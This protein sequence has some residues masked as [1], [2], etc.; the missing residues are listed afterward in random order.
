MGVPCIK[1]CMTLLVLSLLISFLSQSRTEAVPTY[2]Y[3]Y[4]G[5][6]LN[7]TVNTPYQSNLNQLLA[8]LSSNATRNIEFYN[9][10]ASAMGSAD[11]V[12]GLFICRGDMSADVC[13][14]CVAKAT[15]D[16]VIRCPVQKSAMIWYEECMVRYSFRYI[17]SSMATDPSAFPR[18]TLNMSEPDR[19]NQLVRATM[20]D[21]ASQLSNVRA[22]AKKFGTK[23]ATFTPFKFL[24]TLAQCTPDLTGADC[25]RCLVIAINT[26]PGCCGGKQMG[27]VLFL[28]CIVKYAVTPFYQSANTLAPTPPQDQVPGSTIS[29]KG[30]SQIS[31]QTIVVVVASIS[32]SA[33]LFVAGYCYLRRKQRKKYNVIQEENAESLQFDF[34][35]IEGATDKFSDD[36]K[37]GEGGFGV[38]YK[39]ILPNGQEIAVK[40]LS[41]TSGQG[42]GE[43]KN[44]VI[45]VAKLQHRNLVRLLGFFL[46]GEEKILVYEF[47]PNKSLDYFLYD[48]KRREQ[49]DW[50]RRYKI[51]KGIARGI[52]YLH[53]D[54][55]LRVIHRDLKASNILLDQ[56]MNPKISDFGMAKIFGINQTQGNTNRI[57]GTFGYMSPEYA[58]FGQFSLKSDVYSFG[59]LILEILTGEKN[60]SFC[61]ANSSEVL[62]SYA[63]K[64]WRDETPLE[65]LDPTLGDSYTKNEVIRSLHIGLHCVQD[66]PADRPTMAT[67]VLMLNNDSVTLPLPQRPAYFFRS[68][69]DDNRRPNELESNQSTSKSISYSANEVSITE[70]YP[71]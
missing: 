49:L 5:I 14:D 34:A 47:V 7:F 65:L 55:R 32:V 23:E 45:T 52:L 62:L 68:R 28:S 69:T 25:N 71:R 56:D 41:Q 42:L 4:C 12:Y 27:S 66:N 15:K 51:I 50:S 54:S 48:P 20:N 22:G 13:R 36:N 59:V 6:A 2:T 57:V 44:E 18:S 37:L 63:W 9:A 17:F 39:G 67:V 30:K 21:L 8:Y 61:Q 38:V 26:L 31:L 3:H 35:T 33:L 24:Y 29:P 53:E 16:I 11:T 19:F 40:R 58:M 46:E 43:F 10:T 1:F 64:H 70:L 60:S